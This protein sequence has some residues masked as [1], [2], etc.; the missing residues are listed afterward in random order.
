MNFI[1]HPCSS[2]IM[3]CFPLEETRDF[4]CSAASSVISKLFYAIFI[5]IFAVVG[6]TLGAVTGAFVGAKTKMG[7]MPGVAIGAIKGTFLSI[8]LLKI[9][10]IMC[11]SNDLALATRYH[12]LQPINV[13]ESTTF[14]QVSLNEG[15][16]KDSMENIPKL[17]ITEE[18]IWDSL[19]SRIPCSICLEEFLQ[20]EIVHRLPQCNH[21]FHV[22]CLQKWVK[23]HKSCPLCRRNF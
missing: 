4:C 6:A 22:S 5:F 21:M 16:S 7:F 1:I 11:S 17:R 23:S 9:S 12:L 20:W 8:K 13:H 2:F 15:L 19:R 10:L 18:N 14:I 3:P